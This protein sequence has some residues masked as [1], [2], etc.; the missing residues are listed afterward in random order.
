M[1][2][3]LQ[4]SNGVIS[5]CAKVSEGGCRVRMFQVLMKVG[6]N[7]DEVVGGGGG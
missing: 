2:Q 5:R 7:D 3:I 4:S 1:K 6:N